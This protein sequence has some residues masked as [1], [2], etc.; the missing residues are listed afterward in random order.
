MIGGFSPESTKDYYGKLIEQFRK[1]RKD[2]Y[3]EIVINSMDINKLFRLINNKELDELTDWLL[4]GINDLKNA[5]ASFC[6]IS[7]NTPHIVF[8]KL[9]QKTNIP[10]IS[11][12]ETACDYA[13]KK[14]YRKL[15]LLGTKF[16]MNG[17]FFKL[18]YKKYGIEVF[19]PSNDEIDYIQN[20]YVSEI[21]NG[22]YNDYTIKQ[23]TEIMIRMKNE[24][25]LDGMILGC[26]EFPILLEKVNIGI[27][28]MNTT[29][30]HIEKIVEYCLN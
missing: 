1:Y 10:M 9:K 19:V 30:I 18:P 2:D 23:F 7:A 22:I 13:N 12:V 15:G 6:F 16:T 5:G 20:K 21:E 8:D 11:I 27:E 26:T 28:M 29:N 14:G 25:G 3:P 24:N 4:A 17:D